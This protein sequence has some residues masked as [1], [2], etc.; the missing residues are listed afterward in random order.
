MILLVEVRVVLVEFVGEGGAGVLVAGG[1]E[2][3]A[4][5]GATEEEREAALQDPERFLGEARRRR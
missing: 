2:T 3:V 1:V 5:G 4:E